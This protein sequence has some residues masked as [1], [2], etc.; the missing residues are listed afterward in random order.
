MHA[1]TPGRAGICPHESIVFSMRLAF[2]ERVEKAKNGSQ[3]IDGIHVLP[4]C[5]RLF[6]GLMSGTTRNNFREYTE[7]TFQGLIYYKLT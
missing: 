4:Q 6:I 1:Y 2:G 3:T 5:Q 7:D